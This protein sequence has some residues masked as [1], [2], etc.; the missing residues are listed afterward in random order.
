M[1]NI[2]RNRMTLQGKAVQCHES[3]VEL[4]VLWLRRTT[5]ETSFICLKDKLRVLIR[6]LPCLSKLVWL[7]FF[8]FP[9]N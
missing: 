9:C 2:D 3:T 4:A 5:R 6:Y 8:P 7:I 1:Q